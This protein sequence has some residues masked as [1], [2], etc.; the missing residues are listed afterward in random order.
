MQ[1]LAAEDRID[2][3]GWPEENWVDVVRANLSVHAI[4]ARRASW[5]SATLPRIRG[6]AA[7]VVRAIVQSYL[8]FMDHIHRGTAGEISRVLTTER[9]ALLDELNRKQRE[10]LEVRRHFADMGFRS[11]GAALHPM[12]QRAVYF[13]DALIAVQKERVE[14]E[15]SSAALQAALA[16]AKIWDNT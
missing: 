16:A 2:L 11:D 8:D 12:V 13:N 15:A 5:R 14:Q 6:V 3:A 7:N 1:T 4:R 10:L 9:K